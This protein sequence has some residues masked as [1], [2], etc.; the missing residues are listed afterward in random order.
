[1]Q[2]VE[3]RVTEAFVH[4]AVR[5][6][7]RQTG[8]RLVA[9]QWPGGT[10]D[11][12]HV[13]YIVYPTVARDFSPNPRRHSL[14]K[15][16]PDV[17]ALKDTILLLI[18]AKPG[19]SQTDADKLELLLGER[20]EDLYSALR[21]FGRERGFPALVEPERLSIRPALAFGPGAEYPRRPDPWVMLLVDRGGAVQPDRNLP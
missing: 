3:R 14:D 2:G 18:E 8:W 10:D 4:R 15:F 21:T 1:V 5:R 11:E 20:R 19:Y 16:V 17:V 6:Y 7:L 13:L 9:G 12:L